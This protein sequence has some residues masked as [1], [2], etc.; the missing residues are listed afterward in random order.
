MVAKLRK[1]RFEIIC[2]GFA[3]E[4]LVAQRHV[5]GR[6]LVSH[7]G[8][9][10][11]AEAAPQRKWQQQQWPMLAIIGDDDEGRGLLELADLA[12]PDGE[13]IEPLIGRA[14]VGS[15]VKAAPDRLGRGEI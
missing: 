6:V 8:S 9:D 14:G 10:A 5:E 2:V 1:Q 11:N 13:E 12:L 4:G 3:G 15:T 7:E